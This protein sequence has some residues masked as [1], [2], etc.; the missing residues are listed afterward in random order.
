MRDRIY[1]HNHRQ[2]L[3]LERASYRG[4][5]CECFRLGRFSDGPYY[6]LDV[7]SLYPTMMAHACFP[8][9]LLWY[10]DEPDW[11]LEEWD[12]ER[13]DWILEALV[14]VDQPAIAVRR[15]KL[16][17]PTGRFWAY[18]CTPE[19]R[20]VLQHGRI[21][22]IRRG[23]AYAKAPVFERYVEHFYFLKRRYEEEGN[24]VFREMAKMLLNSLYGK[25]GQ[26]ETRRE[27][28]GEGL[29]DDGVVDWVNADTGERG[30]L[31]TVEGRTWMVYSA[32][33][34]GPNSFPA[35]ASMVTAY[36]RMLLWELIRR[37]GLE[38]VYYCDT[39]G[40]I[41][42]QEGYENLKD[43][44]RPGEL[45]YLS[46]KKVAQ[47]IEIRN[48]KDYRMG[49]EW[50]VKG[51]RKDAEPVGPGKFRQVQFLKTRGCWRRGLTD[52]AY[53]RMMV[54]KLKATYDKGVVE[55]DGRVRPFVL[56][57]A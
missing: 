21:L 20:W 14:E 16:V 54:K 6:Y 57:E 8:V 11:R 43:L 1:I 35:I 4:G 53:S 32:E 26:V 47:E 44:I 49:D 2:A 7:N 15:E 50:K 33:E 29:Y 13:R 31:V 41:V 9:R 51:I 56:N 39:D 48:A 30:Q 24:E 23:A 42:D 3:E 40:L 10:E 18:L 17:F 34:P 19:I 28:V 22:K 36:G 27:L 5:R 25:F 38:H 55:E 45:G 37:A 12:L 46:V 52:A